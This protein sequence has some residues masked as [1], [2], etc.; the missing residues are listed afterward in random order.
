MSMLLSYYTSIFYRSL[1]PTM[2]RVYECGTSSSSYIKIS[3]G[4]EKLEVG[5]SCRVHS[6][7]LGFT[8]YESSYILFSNFYHSLRYL[9]IVKSIFS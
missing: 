3:A 8:L 4:K 7:L 9:L 5:K 2:Q 1:E 6:L